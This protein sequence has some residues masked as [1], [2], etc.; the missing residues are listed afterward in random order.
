MSVIYALINPLLILACWFGGSSSKNKVVALAAGIL[1]GCFATALSL[2][3][4]RVFEAIEG[5]MGEGRWPSSAELLV[6][7]F[8]ASIV[9]TL[10]VW[11]YANPSSPSVQPSDTHDIGNAE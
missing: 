1:G 6:G 10:I 8:I 7:G 9:I 2:P 5:K 4:V 3:V 11:E